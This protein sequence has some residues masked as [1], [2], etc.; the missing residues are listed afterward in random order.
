MFQS[1]RMCFTI[2]IF[3]SAYRVSFVAIL[4]LID[5]FDHESMML[6]E[7][8]RTLESRFP[9]PTSSEHVQQNTVGHVRAQLSWLNV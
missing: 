4:P 2:W 8:F 5:D 1:C 7:V 9:V 3:Q 6:A